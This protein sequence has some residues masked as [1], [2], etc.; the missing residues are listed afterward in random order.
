MPEKLVLS[1]SE[2]AA[3]LGLKPTQ[4]YSLTRERSRIRQSHPLPVIRLGK[5][6]AF[7]REAL[8]SWLLA[9]ENGG[10]R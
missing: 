8:V 4:L 10:T 9:N 7:R 2:A 3:L 1:L 6:L 5:R